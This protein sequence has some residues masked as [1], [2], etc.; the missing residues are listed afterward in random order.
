MSA[1][2]PEDA[3]GSV[4]K[5]PF[6][7]KDDTKGMRDLVVAQVPVDKLRA[8]LKSATSAL[9]EVFRDIQAVGQFQLDEVTI[10]LEVTAEGGIEFLGSLSVGGKAA[11]TLK[12]TPPGKR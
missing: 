4:A 8:N 1:G 7:V 6:V 12:F 9:A 5:L 10:G 3:G 2:G 11:I